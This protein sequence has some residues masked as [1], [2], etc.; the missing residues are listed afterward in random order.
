MEHVYILVGRMRMLKVKTCVILFK[1]RS[2]GSPKYK[3]CDIARPKRGFPD[4]KLPHNTENNSNTNNPIIQ[5]FLECA[6]QQKAYYHPK[7]NVRESPWSWPNCQTQGT[8]H[9]GCIYESFTPHHKDLC[10][11]SFVRPVLYYTR[12]FQ[13]MQGNRGWPL[14]WSTV[15]LT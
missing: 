5:P 14:S 15:W 1:R 4:E 9:G 7:S 8:H 3:K 12:H 6:T 13:K 2:W 11:T 10:Y